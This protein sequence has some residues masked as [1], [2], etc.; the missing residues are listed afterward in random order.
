M[1]TSSASIPAS[2]VT[3][4]D[5]FASAASLRGRRSPLLHPER[6]RLIARNL[7]FWWEEYR[8]LGMPALRRRVTRKLPHGR[9]R[10]HVEGQVT[11]IQAQALTSPQQAGA[12]VLPSACGACAGYGQAIQGAARVV[13]DVPE[14]VVLQVLR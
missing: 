5:V 2:P 13:A 3:A 6:L 14:D 11:A 10:M 4:S 8:Q 7:P 1:S 12:E 9:L